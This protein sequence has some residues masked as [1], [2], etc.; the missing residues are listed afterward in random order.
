[1]KKE[2]NVNQII[3][4]TL[5]YLLMVF[6]LSYTISNVIGL[7]TMGIV[8]L[9]IT[10]LVG[11]I[12]K[13]FILFPFSFY[14]VLLIGFIGFLPLNHYKPE[15]V[16]K[17]MD[18][19]FS[20]V[21]NVWSHIRGYEA[22]LPD[23][24]MAFWILIIA[25][26]SF[27]TII[28]MF[29][30]NRILAITPIYTGAFL[31]YWYN[32]VDTAYIMMIFFFLLNIILYGIEKYSFINNNWRQESVTVMSEIFQPWVKITIS[33]GIIIIIAAAILPKAGSLIQWYWLEEKIVERYPVMADLRNDIIYSRQMA[34]GQL[35]NFSQTGFQSEVGQLGGPVE[36]NDQLV[37]KVKASNPMYLRGNVKTTYKDNNWWFGEA[38]KLSYISS[39]P[40]EVVKGQEAELEITNINLASY[41]L[42]SPYQPVEIYINTKSKISIDQ[43][44]QITLEGGRYKNEKYKLKAVIPTFHSS[45]GH[46]NVKASNINRQYLQIPENIS[47]P[48]T[49][50]AT[51][52]AH[53]GKDS[54]EKA[55]LIEEYLR[56][57]YTYNL[58]APHTPIGEDF[59]QHFLFNS[60]EGYCTYF[61]SSM[62]IMLRSIGIPARYVEGYKMPDELDGE[63]YLVRQLNAHAWV[64]AYFDSIGWVTFEPTPA[65]SAPQHELSYLPE[66]Q[67]NSEASTD[68]NDMNEL[69][70]LMEHSNNEAGNYDFEIP[71]ESQYGGNQ[72]LQ[73]KIWNRLKELIPFAILIIIFGIL[74]LRVAYMY[75][76]I[77]RYHKRLIDKDDKGIY[78]YKNTIE[79]LNILGYPINKGETSHEHAQR[80]NASVYV[81]N[82]DL[83]EIANLYIT[84]KYSNTELNIS[85][86]QR[87]LNYFLYTE[88]K[89]RFHLGIWRYLYTKYVKGSLFTM[90]Y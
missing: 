27:F 67:P 4:Y 5:L 10:M 23:Y 57:N 85:N 87:L 59:I 51:E 26:I 28:I 89:V 81:P 18:W 9:I 86:K 12:V 40:R 77:K 75:F 34:R 58:E 48:I 47:S 61:A 44:Y 72:Q 33:Y 56:E 50:L 32:Y 76:R 13:L 16:F 38:E 90:H 64:E 73:N 49:E 8:K 31:Y 84:A 88:R 24:A 19:L 83:R 60:K 74:P 7:S 37:M 25:I 53:K 17:L 70:A 20:F 39:I 30:A 29:K 62:T 42:F 69:L 6:T 15:L 22:I 66:N 82:E 52:I 45:I 43:N 36:L 21:D 14:L 11:I 63:Y 68:A 2:L 79:L 35:F 3:M 46:S 1:M 78:M 65:F 41:T 55:V 71:L 54:Y 80:V